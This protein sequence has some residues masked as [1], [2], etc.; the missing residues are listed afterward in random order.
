L[1]RGGTIPALPW[2]SFAPP[3]SSGVLQVDGYSAYANLAKTRAKTGSNEPI[4]LA[5][6]SAHL[7]R[8]F[9]DLHISG[10]SQA[11]TD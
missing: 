10:V 1:Y 4:Q 3:L 2:P 7:R 6:C 11:A 8:K 5:G 9:Y